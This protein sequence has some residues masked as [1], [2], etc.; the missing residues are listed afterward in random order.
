MKEVL[1]KFGNISVI[2][3]FEAK[4]V[5]EDDLID[6]MVLSLGSEF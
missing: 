5:S 1:G 4:D 6:A 2:E 3:D